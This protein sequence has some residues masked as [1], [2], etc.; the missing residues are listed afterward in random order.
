MMKASIICS[1][2]LVLVMGYGFSQ[3]CTSD[4]DCDDGLFC[5]GIEIC[6]KEK[7]RCKSTGSPCYNF[8]CDEEI[9]DCIICNTHMDCGAYNLGN[10]CSDNGECYWVDPEPVTITPYII[11]QSRWFPLPVFFNI[12]FSNAN[13]DTSSSVSFNPVNA[14]L[15]LPP[16]VRMKR[17]SS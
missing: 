17:I 4:E 14:I 1:L 6:D 13:F 10:F 5:N 11:L 7:N 9:G 12:H 2:L 3:A 8:I 15:A 16:M